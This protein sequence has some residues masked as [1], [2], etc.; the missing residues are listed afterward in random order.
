MISTYFNYSPRGARSQCSSRRR[1][2]I[3]IV[4][5]RFVAG[6]GYARRWNEKTEKSSCWAKIESIRNELQL[7]S[8]Y[9]AKYKSWA[10]AQNTVSFPHFTFCIILLQQ[11]SQ[12]QTWYFWEISSIIKITRIEIQFAL[13]ILMFALS[14]KSNETRRFRRKVSPKTQLISGMKSRKGLSLRKRCILKAEN[15]AVS[16]W[17]NT[18]YRKCPLL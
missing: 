15:A 3:D 2:F 17:T 6:V 9:C 16:T 4:Q 7:L 14:Q 13:A 11:P 12:K 1:Q 8:Q 18:Y 10:E 5:S